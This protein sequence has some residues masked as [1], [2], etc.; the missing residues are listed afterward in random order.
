MILNTEPGGCGADTASPASA[1]TDPSRGRMT[2]TP[3]SRSPSAAVAARVSRGSIVVRTGRPRR[4]RVRAI[5]RSPKNSRAAGWPDRRSSC[6]RSSPETSAGRSSGEPSAAST[7]PRRGAR[8][9]RR[10]TASSRRRPGSRSEKSHSTPSPDT[11]SD[12]R[13][14]QRAE[15]VGADRDREGDLAVAL[16]PQPADSDLAHAGLAVGVAVGGDEP[17]FGRGLA[18]ARRQ[19]TPHR[20]VVAAR[21]GRREALRRLLPGIAGLL[22]AAPC[23]DAAGHRREKSPARAASGR[24]A[25]AAGGAGPGCRAAPSPPEGRASCSGSDDEAPPWF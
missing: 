18:G 16:R 17:A 22:T 9:A 12:D 19:L 5:T 20:G 10:T 8:P 23:V 6:I 14:A 25:G 4:A 3:P 2:A 24:S 13:P 7:V 11:G 15:D 1:R 21:P